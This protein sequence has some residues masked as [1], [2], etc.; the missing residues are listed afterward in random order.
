[1]S[2]QCGENLEAGVVSIIMSLNILRAVRGRKAGF[3]P[4]DTRATRIIGVN[5]FRIDNS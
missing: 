3:I 1:M 2:L 4:F 5:S